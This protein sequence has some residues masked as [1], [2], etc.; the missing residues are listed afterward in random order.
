MDLVAV[1]T[2]V[3]ELQVAITQA[4]PVLQ[5]LVAVAAVLARVPVQDQLQ[6]QQGV[7]VVPA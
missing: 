6:L 4:V 3:Q 7:Q 1:E 2:L 5:I